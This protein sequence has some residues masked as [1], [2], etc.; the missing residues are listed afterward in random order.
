MVYLGIFSL[1]N[2]L[3]AVVFLC[4]CMHVHIGVGMCVYMCHLPFTWGVKELN[5]SLQACIG[6][7][8]PT[9]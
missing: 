6:S 8:S 1:G 3:G 5:S 4:M 9:E 2:F 7:T